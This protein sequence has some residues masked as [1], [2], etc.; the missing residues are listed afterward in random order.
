[1]SPY[2]ENTYRFPR[3]FSLDRRSVRLREPIIVT[4]VAKR[5][6]RHNAANHSIESILPHAARRSLHLP[7]RLPSRVFGASCVVGWPCQSAESLPGGRF[8]RFPA[9]CG[10]GAEVRGVAERGEEKSDRKRTRLG[11]DW[12][13]REFELSIEHYHLEFIAAEVQK[14]VLP[15]ASVECAPFP[16]FFS[17][18]ASLP[19]ARHNVGHFE[20]T[21]REIRAEHSIGRTNFAQQFQILLQHDSILLIHRCNH[22]SSLQIRSRASQLQHNRCVCPELRRLR[23]RHFRKVFFGFWHSAARAAKRLQRLHRLRGFGYVEALP[24][25][26][27]SGM[28]HR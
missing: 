15:A 7:P 12:D 28:S 9:Q 2:T 18:L 5:R 4:R 3:G 10:V 17:F 13:R 25:V 11:R 23:R 16:L 22:S 26:K 14:A 21:Q 8:P 20:S 27:P 24:E 6:V 19:I 1:M